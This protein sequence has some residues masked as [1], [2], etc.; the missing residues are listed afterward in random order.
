MGQ[1]IIKSVL[2]AIPVL[3]VVSVLI[4]GGVRVIPGN[5]CFVYL[6]AQDYVDL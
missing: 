2:T 5:I 3:F 1:Y 6:G 4:F